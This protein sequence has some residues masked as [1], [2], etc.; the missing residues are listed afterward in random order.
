M[1]EVVS[2]PSTGGS[3]LFATA[4]I[5]MGS[6]IL[7][8]TSITPKSPSSSPRRYIDAYESLL[9]EV[10]SQYDKLNGSSCCRET[11]I[12]EAKALSADNFEAH[13]VGRVNAFE[14]GLIFPTGSFFNHSCDCNVAFSCSDVVGSWRAL[15]DIPSGAELTISYLGVDVL[16]GKSRRRE[17]LLREKFFVCACARCEAA[18]DKATMLP[19]P[20]CHPRVGRYSQDSSCT[21]HPRRADSRHTA[22]RQQRRRQR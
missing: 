6:L 10:K 9:P 8:E 15:T 12:E 20:G 13:L 11:M 5:A 21:F 1:F 22:Q 19:C 4:H 7:S 17:R 14:G 18:E 3:A 16:A 2:S